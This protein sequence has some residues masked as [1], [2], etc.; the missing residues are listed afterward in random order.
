MTQSK[1]KFNRSYQKALCNS[2]SDSEMID[3][4]D[5]AI[6]RFSGTGL[7]LKGAIGYLFLGR[8]LG[9]RALM[10]MMSHKTIAIYD[11]IL[12]INHREFFPEITDYSFASKAFCAGRGLPNFWKAAKG[13]VKGVK[14]PDVDFPAVFLCGGDHE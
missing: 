11:E 14:S 2:L 6:V 12:Q 4:V 3:L 10:L 13:E 7:A 8:Y 9:W 5:R 1:E